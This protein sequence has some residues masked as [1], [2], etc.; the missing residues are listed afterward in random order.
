MAVRFSTVKKL[1]SSLERGALFLQT[2]LL[3][4]V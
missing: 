2:D 4:K 3:S 1:L